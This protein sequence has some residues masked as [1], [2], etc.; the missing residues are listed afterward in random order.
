MEIVT[1]FV[2]AG[3]KWKAWAAYVLWDSLIGLGPPHAA[4]MEPSS[5][6][7]Q[8]THSDQPPKN[9][10]PTAKKYLEISVPQLWLK[11]ENLS[12]PVPVRGYTPLF[13]KLSDRVIDSKK[14]LV[15]VSLN[16]S[17]INATDALN[18]CW[19]MCRPC[20]TS[21]FQQLAPRNKPMHRSR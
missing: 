20:S 1:S 8:L 16:C 14:D 5:Y 4:G 12:G 15:N 2:S 13:F 3:R 10:L 11:Y 7:W 9:N 18:N 21:I 17:K 19:Q 6:H